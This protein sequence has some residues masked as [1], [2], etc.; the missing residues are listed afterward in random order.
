MQYMLLIYEPTGAYEGPAGEALLADIVTGHLALADELRGKGVQ[1]AGAGLRGGETAR[2]VA[3]RSGR[4]SVHDGPFA[5]T[6]EELGGFYLI[7]VASDD[8]ALEIAQ[9]VPMPEGGKVE[10]RALIVH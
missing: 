5:E 9:R 4:R 8:E 1:K 3:M 6:R 2:T 10:V 7:E